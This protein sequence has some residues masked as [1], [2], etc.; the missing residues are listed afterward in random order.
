MTQHE[1]KFLLIGLTL[2]LVLAF[3]AFAVARLWHPDHSAAHSQ[4]AP[5]PKYEAASQAPPQEQTQA[6]TAVSSIQLDQ[7]EQKDVGVETVE[8]TRR[9]LQRA[10]IAVAKVDEPETQLASI[11]ARIGGRIDKLYV[12]FT[13]Q[14]VRRGQPV[15]SIYSP[16]VFS[17]AEEYRLALENRNRL[18]ANAEPAA[19][20]G[21]SDLVNASRRRLELWGLTA[22]QLNEIASSSK[23]KIELP[24]YATVNGIVTERKVSQGQYINAGDVL[25]TV[26]DLSTIWVRAG[27]YQPDLPSVHT[28]QSVEITS[29]SLPGTAL[30]GRV[31]FLDTSI[32]PQTR[33]ASARIQVPN[34][35]MRLRPGMFVQV[36]FAAPAGHEV[37]AI[38]R[39]AVLD[40][41]MRKIVYVAKNNG[42]FEGRQVQLGTPGNDYYPVL[43]GLK[44]GE[45]IVRQGNF[46]I[47][48]QTRITGGMTGLY[49]GSKEFDRGQAEQGQAQAP[50]VAQIKLFF[51]SDPETP[52]GNS[53]ATL[54]VTALD[55]SG[56]PVTDL[57]VKVSLI[58]PAMPAMGMGEMR[59][60][61]DLAWKGTEYVGTIKVP[62]AGSWNVEVNAGRNGQILGSYHARLNAQ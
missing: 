54:H 7:K 31:G 47:D 39:S 29:D 16:E 21:A 40:T 34:P 38:P 56:K 41:G 53:T 25:F 49:G 46:L 48:S 51:R 9:N 37:L 17:T 5:I 60:A 32:N 22:E 55:P 3:V 1:K 19:V 42:E 10:L 20:S 59:S 28:G 12:D 15:A 30:H 26:T 35:S 45:H 62:M 52:R 27:V 18:G 13:G 58:M 11:S 8:V 14:P 61:T 43:S 4:E 57:H 2:G 44:E 36:K 24:I 23:P 50:A 33:A 6:G